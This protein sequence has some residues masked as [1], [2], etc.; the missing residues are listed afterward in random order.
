MNS[1]IAFLRGV[2]IS[3]KNRV[4]MPELKAA[5][6][7]AGFTG[8]ATHLNSGNVL[9][10]SEGDASMVRAAVESV[11]ATRFGV[12][13]PA[14][15]ISREELEDILAH[16]PAWWGSGDKRA[17][18]N[19]IFILTDDAPADICALAGPPS[20]GA[21]GGAGLR[22]RHILELRPQPLPA[23]RLVEEHRP[24]GP[25]RAA[26]HSHGRYAP[27]GVRAGAVK[28]APAPRRCGGG[29]SAVRKECACVGAQVPSQS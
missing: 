15:V 18:D 19:L 1:F 26:D 28:G 12:S 16:A 7:E 24:R 29:P 9:L 21:G 13:A 23:V 5:L 6:E 11:L 17:Y 20:E 8:V 4:A 27:E 10:A 25:C 22:A 14:H 3:G 2:N